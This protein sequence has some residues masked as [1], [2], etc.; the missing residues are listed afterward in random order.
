MYEREIMKQ[1]D[2][3]DLRWGG[4]GQDSLHL[5]IPQTPGPR[6][7]LLDLCMGYEALA[8][9]VLWITDGIK[10]VLCISIRIF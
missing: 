1:L 3:L 9:L 4:G 5:N 6:K 8:L 7:N 10:L 2:G